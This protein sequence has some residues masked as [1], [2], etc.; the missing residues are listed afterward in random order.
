MTTI[1]KRMIYRNIKSKTP[2]E[3]AAIAAGL[4]SAILENE[5]RKRLASC[6]GVLEKVSEGTLDKLYEP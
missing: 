2:E 5:V 6:E 1:E 3:Q 4:D